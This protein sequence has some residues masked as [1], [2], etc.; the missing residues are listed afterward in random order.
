V[1]KPATSFQLTLS[2][3]RLQVVLKLLLE[4]VPELL[5]LPDVPELLELPDVPKLLEDVPE[6]LE[7]LPDVPELLELEDITT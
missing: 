6:L 3:G 1:L 4:D 2:T 5:E 7:E